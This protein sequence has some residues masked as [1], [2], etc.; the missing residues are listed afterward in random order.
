MVRIENLTP[1]V[2]LPPSSVWGPKF[3]QVGKNKIKISTPDVM[4]Y[5]LDEIDIDQVEY[6]LFET[7]GAQELITISRND[8]VNGQDVKVQPIKNIKDLSQ[9]YNSRNLI[10]AVDSS[11]TFFNNFPISLE[12]Y[13]PDQ[14]ISPLAE[15]DSEGNIVINLINVTNDQQIEIQVF[16]GGNIFDD[17]IYGGATS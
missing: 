4:V 2:P 3:E 9:A 13:L 6:L 10:S 16:G 17:T 15:A 8:I 11:Y 12:Q 1:A 7:V 5:T 14:D